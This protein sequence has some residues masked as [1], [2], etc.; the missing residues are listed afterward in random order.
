MPLYECDPAIEL[1]GKSASS[2]IENINYRNIKPILDRHGLNTIDPE[3]WY[4]LQSLLNVL[5]DIADES[6]STFNFVS[7]GMAA[8]SSGAIPPQLQEM[9]FEA[10]LLSY[11]KIYAMRHR[12]GEAGTVKVEKV[13]DKHLKVSMAIPYPEDVF[14]G[15]IYAYARRLLPEGTFVAVVYDE[16]TPR[17][18]HGGDVAILH[19]KWE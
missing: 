4:P 9:G 16:A 2:L 10:V 5:R 17:P 7:I 3:G 8:G 19:V 12:N 14:Y 1:N 18:A 13:A 11:D 6:G 15:V